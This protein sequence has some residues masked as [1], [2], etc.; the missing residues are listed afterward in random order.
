MIRVLKGGAT[1]RERAA[2]EH[3]LRERES[4]RN[5]SKEFGKP[6]LRTPFEINE[7]PTQCE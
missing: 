4:A 7:K 3:A 1:E 5:Q 2:I 6:I